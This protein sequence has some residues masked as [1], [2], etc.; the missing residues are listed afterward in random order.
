[1]K[2]AI[3][4]GLVLCT[5]SVPRSLR[6]AEPN[7]YVRMPIVEQG[8]REVD[9]KIGT[10]NNSEGSLETATS[11]GLG[12]GISSWWFTEAYA[13][14]K[15]EPGKSIAF[16]AWEWENQFQLTETGK[17]PVDVGFLLEIERP[18]DREEGY[19]I[20]YGPEFQSEWG[21]IQGNINFL[22]Q[23]HLDAS[24]EF[25][26]ELQ[27]QGQVKYRQFEMFEWGAQSFGSVGKW[28]D[29]SPVGQQLHSF[30]PAIF[31]KFKTGTT[32]AVKWNAGALVGLTRL[33]PK[34]TFRI[35]TEYEF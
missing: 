26:T 17:F 5:L 22:V 12:Y 33:S 8:E 20:T 1:M 10:L 35:Q 21:Q 7:D 15:N 19:E 4:A 24:E 31:G 9:L 16:D 30:G 3:S 18:E 25:N 29:W 23:S 32:Q 14:W 2:T 11:L 6:A 13:K 28:N 34:M 27:Y